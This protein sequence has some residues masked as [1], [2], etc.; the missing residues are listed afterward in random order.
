MAVYNALDDPSRVKAVIL[1][2]PHNPLSRVYTPDMIRA[3]MKFCHKRGMHFISDEVYALASL[4]GAHNNGSQFVSAL[5]V[6]DANVTSCDTEIDC[7]RTHVV[8]SPSKLF[9]ISGMR[10]VSNRATPTC[11]V[12]ERSPCVG[13][14]H[15]SSQSA[16]HQRCLALDLS[17]HI[18]TQ[19]AC[20][21]GAFVLT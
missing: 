12:N 17:Q 5:A 9:G 6:S 16:A 7:S 21:E 15:L 4:G 1:T 8:W 14:P 10:V 18:F 3:C 20:T 19:R 2:N 13:M 11:S